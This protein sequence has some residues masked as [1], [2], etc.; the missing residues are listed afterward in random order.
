MPKES[1]EAVAKSIPSIIDTLLTTAGVPFSCEGLGQSCPSAAS[2]HAWV[3]ELASEIFSVNRADMM[4]APAF[5]LSI[6][7]GERSKMPYHPKLVAYNFNPSDAEKSCVTVVL[8]DNDPSK[9]DSPS[10]GG[11]GNSLADCL[12]GHGLC[13]PDYYFKIQ[14]ALHNLQN[15]LKNGVETVFGVGGIEKRNMMQLLHSCK[16]LEKYI[17]DDELPVRWK[18]AI[19]NLR[20]STKDDADD[21]GDDDD[22]IDED[23]RNLPPNKIKKAVLTQWWYVLC[24]AEHLRENWDLWKAL[25]DATVA[26][27][28]H[29]D[30][31][32]LKIAT[33]LQ[34]DMQE[35]KIK[36]DVLFLCGFGRAFFTR[37]FAFMQSY[38]DQ[39][40][41]YGFK[42]RSMCER[43]FIMNK[44][45][46]ALTNDFMDHPEFAEWKAVIAGE[47][48]RAFH[49]L[50]VW[51]MPGSFSTGSTRTLWSTSTIGS[52]KTTSTLP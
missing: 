21:G 43:I 4:Y 6:D 12:G 30:S 39:A 22:Q 50:I 37:H 14:C 10:V 3:V 7:K 34:S 1:I 28:Q 35:Q 41:T 11:V 36:A 48:S 18:Q 23:V 8:L 33:Y 47:L 9:G 20:M 19:E 42:S 24:A 51:H 46:L 15:A 45:L 13:H 40:K 49:Q 52:W 16:D 29:L 31:A 44:E 26:G 38:D 2:L 32:H 27:E 25:A 5:S 17:C